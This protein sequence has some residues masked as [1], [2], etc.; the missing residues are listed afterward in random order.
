MHCTLLLARCQ[1][2]SGR[3]RQRPAEGPAA[4][5]GDKISAQRD[6]RSPAGQPELCRIDR[7]FIAARR[8]CDRGALQAVF[9]ERPASLKTFRTIDPGS[10]YLRHAGRWRQPVTCGSSRQGG[11]RII[12]ESLRFEGTVDRG[13]RVLPR[14]QKAYTRRRGPAGEFPRLASRASETVKRQDRR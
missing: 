12:V 8:G 13:S 14:C 9:L 3:G 4:E 2:P 6:S 11:F 10:T 1:G 5:A 7:A